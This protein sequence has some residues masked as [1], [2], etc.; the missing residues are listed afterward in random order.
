VLQDFR[1]DTRALAEFAELFGGQ[2]VPPGLVP[3]E[4]LDA[5]RLAPASIRVDEAAA[6]RAV[7]ADEVAVREAFAREHARLLA[8]AG[9]SHFDVSEAHSKRRD[10]T[11]AFSRW[12]YQAGARG[13]RFRSNLDDQACFALFEGRAWLEARGDAVVLDESC[14][15]LA[16]VLAEF[17]LVVD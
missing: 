5:S 7:D 12:S 14:D 10:V 6:D 1:P 16:L 4:L 3:R 17:D 15:E 9:M 13:V 2:P 11:R 8:S